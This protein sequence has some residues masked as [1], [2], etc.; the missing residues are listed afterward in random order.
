MKLLIVSNMPHHYRNGQIVG[1]GPTVQE[2]DSLAMIFDQIVHLGSLYSGEAPLSA[3]PYHA[4]NIQFIPLP[5]AG[6]ESFHS[7]LEIL[8]LTP[9][10]VSAIRSWLP[11]ADVVHVRCPAN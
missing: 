1:W 5:P 6:G 7:K 9:G 8:R 2:I 4:K 3:L 10:Y 11:W